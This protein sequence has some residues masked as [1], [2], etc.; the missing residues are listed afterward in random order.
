MKI[1]TGS[2]DKGKTSL[3]SGERVAKNNLRI[4]ACG[5][6]DELN[7]VL[8]ML[9]AV[10]DPAEAERAGEVEFIQSTLFHVGAALA[11]KGR[12][13][14]SGLIEV[15]G[16]RHVRFLE[17]AIDG[18][19]ERLPELRSFILP[20]GH[21]SA[22]VSHMA[23]TVCR[24]VERRVTALSDPLST[25]ASANGFLSMLAF[26]NRLSDYLFTLARYCNWTHKM[27]DKEWG[28]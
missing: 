20:G 21:L 27:P 22:G 9:S 12:A 18:M 5:D 19:S 17:H 6:V 2:G 4:E 11:T 10:L 14:V 13:P 8:G 24:R 26:L 25:G 7:S 23:R 28:K 3:F 1:Y 15:V 16:P